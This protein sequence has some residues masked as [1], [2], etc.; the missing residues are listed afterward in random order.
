MSHKIMEYNTIQKRCITCRQASLTRAAGC[1]D[2]IFFFYTEN[3]QIGVTLR[4][5][6]SGAIGPMHGHEYEI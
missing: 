3:E 6:A 1:L 4:I 2:A 5:S